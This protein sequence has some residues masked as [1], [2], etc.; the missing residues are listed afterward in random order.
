MV[1]EYLFRREHARCFVRVHRYV[2]PS[3]QLNRNT[4]MRRID[5]RR[6]FQGYLGQELYHSFCRLC[7]EFVR[8]Y[9]EPNRNQTK[10]NPRTDEISY[11]FRQF[12]S[13]LWFMYWKIDVYYR[14]HHAICSSPLLSLLRFVRNNG[15]RFLFLLSHI[16]L[17]YQSNINK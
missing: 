9:L 11:Q 12:L 2:G 14:S 7:L 13:I 10:S 5:E 16:L 15:M 17:L 4:H 8:W 1:I 6:E 3:H